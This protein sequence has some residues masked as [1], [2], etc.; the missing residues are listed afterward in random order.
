MKIKT[1]TDGTNGFKGKSGKIP[2]QSFSK[3][4]WNTSPIG[5]IVNAA[6]KAFKQ[7]AMDNAASKA[8]GTRYQKML[9]VKKKIAK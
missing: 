8:N 5:G 7:S 3:L 9:D 6:G 4:A 1:N 2:A